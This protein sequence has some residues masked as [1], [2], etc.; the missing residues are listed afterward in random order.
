MSVCINKNSIEYQSLKERAGISEFIL[1]SV[2]RDYMDR[3]GRFPYLDE[4]PNVNSELHLKDLL[5][6]KQ[7]GTVKISDLLEATG[8]ET[9][10]EAIV[11]IN[12]QYRDLETRV[13][14]IVEEGIVDIIHRPTENNFEEI[15][16]IQPNINNNY[17]VLNNA[18][19]K[20]ADL[21]L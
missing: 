4:L 13:L 5:H 2:C 1:E 12:N 3:Y 20:L 10:D 16:Q 9:V 17:V 8:K 21:Y 19:Q 11:D 18:L 15:E 14:P 7:N 6:V